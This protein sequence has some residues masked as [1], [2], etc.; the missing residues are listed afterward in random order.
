MAGKKA[1]KRVSKSR[2]SKRPHDR[3]VKRKP[4]LASPKGAVVETKPWYVGK[5][6]IG[7]LVEDHADDR[8]RFVTVENVATFGH[9]IGAVAVLTRKAGS[10]FA[11]HR[12]A[13]EG[14]TCMLISGLADYHERN[15][16]GRMAPVR[17][18]AFVPLFTPPDVDHAF[19]AVTDCVMVV[20]ANISRTQEEYERDIVRLK[21]DERLV[22]AE[23]IAA[24]TPQ[25][26]T[27]EKIG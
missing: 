18:S 1:A 11:E 26:P 5:P 17:M 7:T 20:I 27:E 25:L 9:P 14:H 19:L 21:D 8:G 10:V 15:A 13:N 24:V 22:S 6:L 16:T 4:R 12:H 23:M 2:G 3:Q